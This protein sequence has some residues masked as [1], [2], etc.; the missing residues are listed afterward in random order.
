MYRNNTNSK[1]KNENTASAF[2][3]GQQKTV[4]LINV[5]NVIEKAMKILTNYGEQLKT[6]LDFNLTQKDKN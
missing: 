5:T 4:E 2:H 1:S 6:Q 3:G